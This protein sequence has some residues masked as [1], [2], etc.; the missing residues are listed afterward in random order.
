MA[1]GRPNKY[2]SHVKPKLNVIAAWM[3][4]GLTID[5]VAKNLGVAAGT[6]YEYQKK[7]PELS[8]A[9]KESR[10]EADQAVENALYK[11]ATEGDNTAM[12]FWLKNRQPKRWRDKQESEIYGNVNLTAMTLEQAEDLIKQFM[13]GDKP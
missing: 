6:M 4:N 1:G 10:E 12:I 11:K 2:D 5:Q 13:G 3:R 8:E 9:L 7:Y